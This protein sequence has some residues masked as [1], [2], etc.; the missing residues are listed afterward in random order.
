MNI[1]ID[2]NILL[3][4][5]HL[6]SDD[7]EEL[8]KLIILLQQKKVTLWLPEQTKIEFKRNRANKIADALK[9]LQEQRLNMQ[10]PQLAKEY[11]EYGKLRKALKES[12]EIFSKLINNI[13][14]DVEKQNLKADQIIQE[15]MGLAKEIKTTSKIIEKS[16]FRYDIENPPGKKD[17][18]GDSINWESF[19]EAMPSGDSLYFI[20]GDKDYISPLDENLFEPYLESEWSSTKLSKI[21]YYK[22]LSSFFKDKFPEIKLASELEKDLLI[23]ELADSRNFSNTHSV[24]AKLKNYVEFSPTQVNEISQAALLNTQV[25]WIIEDEDVN[26]FLKQIVK[27]YESKID[28]DYLLS[29]KVILDLKNKESDNNSFEDIP[30]DRIPTEED[31]PF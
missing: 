24:I 9:R 26:Q 29:L 7:L 31:L 3:S 5:Y 16:R 6:S 25:S 12:D 28:S 22:R 4:F 15:L 11:D 14:D 17:S 10:F 13:R 1:Y 27:D 19:L 2:T 20:S 18:L 30:F 23:R 8:K 21:I